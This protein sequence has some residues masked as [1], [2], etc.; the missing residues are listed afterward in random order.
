MS[1]RFLKGAILRHF[2]FSF[3]PILF[4]LKFKLQTVFNTP[5]AF[6]KENVGCIYRNEASSSHVFDYVTNGDIIII[7]ICGGE[8]GHHR[9]HH[10]CSLIIFIAI[11]SSCSERYFLF[12][13]FLVGLHEVLELF[14]VEPPVLVLVV[15]LE[16]GVDLRVSHLL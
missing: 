2:I 15:L 7:I 6:L 9:F 16:H 4:S 5:R 14:K 1:K 10:S 3:Y 12:S 11:H 8:N 13:S